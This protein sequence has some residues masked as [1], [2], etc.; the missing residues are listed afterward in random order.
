LEALYA[1]RMANSEWRVEAKVPPDHSPFAI[2]HSPGAALDGVRRL[3]ELHARMDTAV[4]AAYG[5][6]DL[7]TACDFILDYEEEEDEGA[8]SEPRIANGGHGSTRR[9][10][11]ATRRKKPWRYRWPDEVR[12]EVLARLLKLNAE[13]AE[14]ERLAGVA[15]AATT[16]AKPT[17]PRGRHSA[18]SP[19]Q[20]D[21]LPPQQK[22]L[23]G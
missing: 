22:E 23:F 12:D 11:I 13:R 16:P 7:P 19:T 8:N 2:Y 17:K 6:T 15:A 3:R 4:L 5:W 14:E 1:K 9:S 20:E 10:P 18:G 21:S